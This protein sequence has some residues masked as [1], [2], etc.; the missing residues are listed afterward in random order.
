MTLAKITVCTPVDEDILKR[1]DALCADIHRTRAEVLRGLLYSL[2][3]QDKHFIIEEWRG[4]VAV[5]GQ[6]S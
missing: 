2:L 4:H 1:L 6:K 5:G 3:L